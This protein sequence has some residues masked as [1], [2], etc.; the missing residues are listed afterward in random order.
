MG[1]GS[2]LIHGVGTMCFVHPL[3]CAVMNSP[4]NEQFLKTIGNRQF[5][6]DRECQYSGIPIN[7]ESTL[8]LLPFA[9]YPLS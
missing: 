7:R 4:I 3:G 6:I 9:Y 2:T 5:A 8:C 1:Y